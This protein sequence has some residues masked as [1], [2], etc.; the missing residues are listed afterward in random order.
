M[1][2]RVWQGPHQVAWKSTTVRAWLETS[3]LRCDWEVTST[4]DPIVEN[5][6]EL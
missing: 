4:G 6:T 5:D 2:A 1:G 3:V